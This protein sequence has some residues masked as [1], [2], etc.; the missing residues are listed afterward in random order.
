MLQVIGSDEAMIIFN[1]DFLVIEQSITGGFFVIKAMK[2][3]N[4]IP[5]K[6][7]GNYNELLDE[8]KK[9]SLLIAKGVEVVKFGS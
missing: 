1:P 2:N 3:G 6:A 4:E 5:L 8:L 7:S 9:V